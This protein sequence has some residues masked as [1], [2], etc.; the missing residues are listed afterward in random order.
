MTKTNALHL[1]PQVEK[2]SD[3]IKEQQKAKLEKVEQKVKSKVG[4]DNL[5]FHLHQ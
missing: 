1:L 2:K 4:H 5:F 3:K